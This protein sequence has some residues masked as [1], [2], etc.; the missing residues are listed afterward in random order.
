MALEVVCGL[1]YMHALFCD[2]LAH[3]QWIALIH[4]PID[5]PSLDLHFSILHVIFGLV[6]CDLCLGVI[7]G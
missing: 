7:Y 3:M 5:R 1:S 6:Y 2:F 4:V